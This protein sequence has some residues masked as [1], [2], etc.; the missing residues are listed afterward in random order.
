MYFFSNSPVKW[1]C[2]QF[3]RISSS[4]T[5]KGELLTFTKVVFPVPP[6]PTIID[7]KITTLKGRTN[8]DTE[9]TAQKWVPRTG[10]IKEKV[11]ESLLVST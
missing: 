2:N 5:K 9:E 1:R 10:S 3:V 11:L 4:S 7:H 8:E 6:S